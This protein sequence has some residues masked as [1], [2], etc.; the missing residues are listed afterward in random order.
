MTALPATI[1]ECKP[2]ARRRNNIT[3]LHQQCRTSATRRDTLEVQRDATVSLLRVS[4]KNSCVSN[5]I[6]QVGIST[7]LSELNGVRDCILNDAIEY[8]ER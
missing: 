6:R 1:V 8:L 3:V 5:F 7:S 2:V 4:A